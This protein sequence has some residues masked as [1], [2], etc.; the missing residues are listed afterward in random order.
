VDVSDAVVAAG[1]EL[2]FWFELELWFELGFLDVEV[3]FVWVTF[4]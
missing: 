3:T 1:W 4:F 2:G